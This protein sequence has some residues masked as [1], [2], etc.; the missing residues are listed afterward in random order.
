MKFLNLNIHFYPE[1]LGGA[2]VVAEKMAWGLVRAG[3]EVTS[4]Y[5]SRDS[6]ET[7]LIV[8]DTPFGRS[9]GITGVTP[10]PAN[11]FSNPR[12][13]SLLKEI[14]D[15]V[16][17]DRI[18]VHAV[19]HMGVHDLLSDPSLLHRAC[20]VAHDFYW[21]CLQGFRT[22]PDGATCD[23]TI[24]QDSCRECAWFPG[25]TETIYARA[26]R[27]LADSRAVIFPSAFLR[28]AY[29]Q[30]LGGG[31]DHFHTLSNPD[32]AQTVLPDSAALPPAPGAAARAA[33]QHVL[34]FVGGPGET[35][36]WALVRAFMAR[37]AETAARPDGLHV[38]LFDLGRGVGAPWYSTVR[39]PGV[40]IADPFHWTYAAQAM[41]ALHTLLMPSRVRESFGLAAREALSL[42]QAT[43]IRPSG[44]LAELAG[45][46]RVTLARETD[47]V[48]T[49]L[50]AIADSHAATRPEWPQMPVADYVA[51]IASL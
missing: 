41:G 34:G 39:Q 16:A 19:Q 49:L 23:R 35:K 43:V 28:S 25:M 51:K 1:S 5:L 38:V 32:V 9:I 50:D 24:G 12:V 37:A 8:R 46:R 15:M 21:L 10:S 4:V 40:T 3:H 29:E 17:P 30:I 11:R 22:L 42:G 27:V 6:D 48:A 13:T 14:V 31:A 47:D 18:V 33:G 44:A 45:H 2:T 36:G 7:D 20:I 26:R